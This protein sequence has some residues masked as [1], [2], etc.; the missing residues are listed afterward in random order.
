MANSPCR[1]TSAPHRRTP[2]SVTPAISGCRPA[3]S[4]G[5]RD[6]AR[7]R[8]SVVM[9]HR[10]LGRPA[11]PATGSGN[12]MPH[13]LD[14]A[15]GLPRRGAALLGIAATITSGWVAAPKSRPRPSTRV[16]NYRPSLRGSPLG[17]RCDSTGLYLHAGLRP[18]NA[19]LRPIA[20]QDES[21]RVFRSGIELTGPCTRVVKLDHHGSEAA[22]CRADRE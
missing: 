7:T 19:E 21:C 18:P 9:R 5:W 12:A 22:A 16:R 3:Y 17:Y 11:H 20:L 4:S 14:A 2:A 1:G 13:H 6:A 8:F 10:Y 15:A